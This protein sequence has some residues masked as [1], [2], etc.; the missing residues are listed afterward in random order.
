[1]EFFTK[2]VDGR[3]RKQFSQE[4]PSYILRGLQFESD[5]KHKFY[6]DASVWCFYENFQ[7]IC[8]E[9]I[10]METILKKV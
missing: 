5:L 1:M 6:Y 2:I 7:E 10:V 3:T 9:T 8:K 4:D